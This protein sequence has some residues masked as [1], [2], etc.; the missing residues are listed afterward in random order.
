M[1]FKK[2]HTGREIGVVICRFPKVE[3]FER[4]SDRAEGKALGITLP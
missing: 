1:D 3:I 2:A 4:I